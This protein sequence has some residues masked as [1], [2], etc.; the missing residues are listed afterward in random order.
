MPHRTILVSF[1]V[2]LPALL[3]AGCGGGGG[4]GGGGGEPPGPA[5]TLTYG[6]TNVVYRTDAPIVANPPVP[7]NWVPTSYDVVPALPDGLA[8]DPPTGVITGVPTGKSPRASYVVT[9]SDGTN[10]VAATVDIEILWA[11]QKSLTPAPELDEDDLRHFLIR[12]HWGVTTEKL[13][14]LQDEGLPTFLDGM[15]AFPAI[16]STTWEQ[17]AKALLFND[18]LPAGQE[19]LFPNR[20]QMI[21]WW[22]D[23]MKNNENPFQEVLAMHW[24]DHFATSSEVVSGG[25]AY[26]MVNHVNML[27]EKGAGD[28]REFLLAI[29]RDWAMLWWLD[30][31]ISTKNNPNENFP[32]EW[33]ELFCLGVDNGYDQDDIIEAARAFTGYQDRV[34]DEDTGLRHM[35]FVPSRH[36]DTDKT[37]LGQLIPGQNTTDDYEAMVDITLDH[38][39]TAEWIARSLLRGFVLDEPSEVLVGQLAA[40]LRGADYD[41]AAALRAMFQ[42]EAFFSAEA[43]RS[44]VKSPV[45]HALGFQLSTG[46]RVRVNELHYALD[47]M[48]NV[49]TMPPTVDGWPG[50]EQWLSAHGMVERA[51]LLQDAISDSDSVAEQEAH[52]LDLRAQ[53][54][55]GAPTSLEVVDAAALHLGVTLQPDERTRLAEYLDTS[56]DGAGVVTA[57]PFD[58]DNPDH[59]DERIRGLLYILGQHPTYMVR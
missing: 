4:G 2:L 31:Y 49:P 32:R 20:T 46:L 48:G 3:V 51:N 5:A 11:E 38:G 53:L 37:V 58:A 33:L 45:D 43:R 27:R 15:L 44:L 29:S 18:D 8:L 40:V 35:E 39:P 10:E 23:L 52:G 21:R 13:Q 36:D 24:H 47:D 14:E 30:G 22:L 34:L 26:Y 16:E 41:L 42:S 56:R 57:D 7:A 59:V 50:G 12:T 28:L 19:Y 1:L 25:R 9:A 55:P 17:D 54:P 6:E